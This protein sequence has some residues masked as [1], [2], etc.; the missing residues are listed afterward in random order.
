MEHDGK[1]RYSRQEL[2]QLLHKR[3]HERKLG[4]VWERDDIEHEQTLDNDFVTLELDEKVSVG[5]AP[6]QDL[7]IE[8]D[9]F[10]ALRYLHMAYK[11]QI[12]CI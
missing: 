5:V 10:D 12:K 9:N 4:L 2:L 3:D 8:G 11:G 1:L 6:F 7:L